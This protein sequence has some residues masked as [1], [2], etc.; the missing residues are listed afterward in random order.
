MIAVTAH[1]SAFILSYTV[2]KIEFFVVRFVTFLFDTPIRCSQLFCG[3]IRSLL[4]YAWTCTVRVLAELMN[5]A[6]V[7]VTP[8]L[9]LL[10]YVSSYFITRID[11]TDIEIGRA[12]FLYPIFVAPA[13]ARKIPIFRQASTNGTAS[14]H[15]QTIRNG[16]GWKER[17]SVFSPVY[18]QSCYRCLNVVCSCFP[19][20]KAT[21]TPQGPIY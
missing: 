16:F 18:D 8:M 3:F 2:K 19:R 1:A 21:Y 7:C 6:V 11:F 5:G 10:L 14:S 13:I 4:L 20:V 15:I 17:N 9:E 12:D